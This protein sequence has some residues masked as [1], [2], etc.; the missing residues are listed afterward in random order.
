MKI[1]LYSTEAAMVL[2]PD[3]AQS[4]ILDD[5]ISFGY[6]KEIGYTEPANVAFTFCEIY[7]TTFPEGFW[8]KVLQ[9]TAAEIRL[10]L[11]DVSGSGTYYE[12]FW[13]RIAKDAPTVTMVGDNTTY[14]GESMSGSVAGFE[15]Q[16]LV[17]GNIIRTASFECA[18]AFVSRLKEVTFS[19]LDTAVNNSS[20]YVE[21]G[22]YRYLELR[23]ILSGMMS[24]GF[25][26]ETAEPIDASKVT[27]EANAFL[28]TNSGGFDKTVTELSIICQ[29]TT[30]SVHIGKFTANDVNGWYYYTC[31]DILKEIL[32]SHCVYARLEFD[33]PSAKHSMILVGKFSTEDSAT[34]ITEEVPI[35][36]GSTLYPRSNIQVRNIAVQNWDGSYCYMI[37]GVFVSGA[38]ALPD[39]VEFD[40]NFKAVFDPSFA[41]YTQFYEM[42]YVSGGVATLIYYI[43]YYSGGW[44][45]S[46]TIARLDEALV[47]YL[48]AHIGSTISS[49]REY[50]REYTAI[51][52]TVSGT[53]SI[54]NTK[55]GLAG[56]ATINDSVASKNFL[57]THLGIN[58][59]LDRRRVTWIEA[60]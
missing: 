28:Y 59:T 15:E 8:Y 10:T 20:F 39:G 49:L 14:Y 47:K 5:F 44:S 4:L 25:G 17:S 31:Y 29:A 27:D 32:Q 38:S 12:I 2:P 58:P 37:N 57:A 30:G 22:G 26:S 7:T 3:V 50:E 36:G 53:A 56:R 42:F 19:E 35:Q 51:R 34:A 55:I 41:I 48:N 52:T 18:D 40:I 23:V 13:G 16:S 21:V 60:V 54:T 9:A 46:N 24:L 33:I 43:R 11:E 1:Y 6:G 45:A